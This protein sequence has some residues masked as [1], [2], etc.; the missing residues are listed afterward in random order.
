MAPAMAVGSTIPTPVAKPYIGRI[1]AGTVWMPLQASAA[2]SDPATAP[3]PVPAAIRRSMPAR[4]VNRAAM[5]LPVMMPNATRPK[6][7]P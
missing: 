6:Q 2:M 3:R 1:T 7:S 5:K 4:G